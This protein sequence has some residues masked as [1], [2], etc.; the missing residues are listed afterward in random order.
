[1]RCVL[2]YAHP[3][4]LLICCLSRTAP[5]QVCRLLLSQ[6]QHAARAGSWAL[7]WAAL[8]GHEAVC[9]LLLSPPDQ[10]P[11]AQVNAR[12]LEQEEVLHYPA[13][14]ALLQQHLRFS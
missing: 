14:M 6:P 7:W 5:A 3:A 12:L 4:A 10:G 2:F 1:M 8:Y 9:R 11:P 13:I